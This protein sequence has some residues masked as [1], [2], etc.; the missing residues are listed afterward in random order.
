M[1]EQNVRHHKELADANKVPDR[2]T[3]RVPIIST[4]GCAFCRSHQCANKFPN[5]N[6]N[7]GSYDFSDCI[8]NTITNIGT[9]NCR[10]C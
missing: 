3:G 5:C 2:C 1:V 10:K 7:K 9:Y 4:H 8:S 6:A